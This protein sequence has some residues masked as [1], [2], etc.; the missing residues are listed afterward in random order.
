M[1][2]LGLRTSLVLDGHRNSVEE[3]PGFIAV[4]TPSNP[5]YFFGNFLLYDR[6]PQTGDADR[7]T[8]EFERIFRDE[9]GV[10]HAAFAWSIVED[11]P[12][13]IGPFVERGYTYQESSVLAASAV[14]GFALPGGLHVRPLHSDADWDAQVELGLANREE[15]YEAEPY[16]R[17]KR[18]QVAHHRYI[19]QQFGAWLGVFDGDRLAGSCGIF[20]AGEGIA[21]YQDVGVHPAYRNR[22]IAHSLIGEAARFANE[23]LRAAQLVIVAAAD[24]FARRIYERAGFTLCARE[25]ALWIAHR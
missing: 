22:G 12:G 24:G 6:A 17:F 9:R 8:G 25:G 18:A 1:R 19:A 11:E 14:R 2:T 20:S 5:G 15:Q 3:H 7:W 21:R 16:A 13:E 10:R 23:R 4:R